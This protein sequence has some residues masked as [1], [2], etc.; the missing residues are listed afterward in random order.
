[1]Q[2]WVKMSLK[3]LIFIPTFNERNNVQRMADEL[4]SLGID[5]DI[6]FMDDNSPDGTGD[7][8]DRLA[9]EQPRLTVLH[10]SGKLGIG[11]AHLDGI[12]WA[13]DHGYERLITMDCDFTHSPSDVVRLIQYSNGYDVTAGSRYMQ[14]NSLP[15]WNLMRRSLT[16]FGHVLTHNLLGI[17][18]DATGALRAYDLRRIPRELFDLVTARGYAFFFESMFILVR[19]GLSVK[20]FPIVLPA[21]TYGSSKMTWR[22]TWR[23]GSHLMSLWMAS[24]SRPSRFQISPPPPEIDP[25]LVD[26]QGWDAYWDRKERPST[27]AYE[28]IAAGYRRSIIKRQLERF[29]FANFPD[30]SR[31][32]HAGCGSGQVDVELNS[33]M[34]VTAVDISPSALRVYRRNNP[35]AYAVRHASILDLP[36]EAASF[37]GVYNLGVLEHFTRDEIG[38]ILAEFLRVLRPGG[39]VVIFWPH[40]RATSVAVLRGAHWLFNNVLKRP[41]EFHPAEISLLK[42]REWA[43]E[44]VRDAGFRITD[45]SFGP[46]DFYVQAVM[47]AEKPTPS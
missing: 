35:R 46:S 17:E 5:A 33:R 34:E 15:G 44:I 6:L 27:M 28:L 42:S 43:Q 20:E 29:I 14:E 24:I 18:F 25:S 1:M 37:D 11:S 13:Y 22:E 31:L 40:A 32:L 39:K 2:H 7:I 9:A 41:T 12:H 30:G 36:F 21:R 8:L 10:R 3:T 26:P 19:N 45:Y 23:S 47:V 16:S 4:L 38:V